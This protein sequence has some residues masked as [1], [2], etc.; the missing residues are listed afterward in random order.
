MSLPPKFYQ[1]HAYPPP[2]KISTPAV[3]TVDIYVD[4]ACRFSCILFTN[5]YENIYPKLS[6]AYGNKIQFIFRHQVQV[7]HPTS[8]MMHEAS[9][10]VAQIKP[11][12]F[13]EVSYRFMK[14]NK[15]FY[16]EATA[17]LSRNEIYEKLYDSCI[18]PYIEGVKKDVFLNKLVIKKSEDP[19]N[20]GNA[21]S[22]DLKAFTKIGRQNSIHATPTIVVNG[23]T[24]GS[25]ESS[26]PLDKVESKLQAL[27]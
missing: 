2:D 5:W 15:Q 13:L 3:N 25:F 16:D 19:K 10:A 12:A 6:E 4:Y 27:L 21:V 20:S 1:S 14:N 22:N 8:T 24:D 7:W 11:E 17:D 26:T 18:G 9:L 23:Y